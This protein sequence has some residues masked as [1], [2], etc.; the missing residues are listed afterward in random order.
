MKYTIDTENKT[1][2]IEDA[3]IEEVVKLAKKY[4]KYRVVSMWN[5]TYPYYPVWPNTYPWYDATGYSIPCDLT[6]GTLTNT[7]GV[8]HTISDTLTI[9]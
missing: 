8:A 2:Q 6:T 7:D 3:T 5:I 1:I 4:K 9:N